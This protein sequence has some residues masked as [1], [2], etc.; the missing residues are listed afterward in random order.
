MCADLWFWEICAIIIGFLGKTELAAHVT[1]I[2]FVNVSF[3][4][5]IGLSGAGATLVGEAIGAQNLLRAKRIC[6]DIVLINV[7]GWSLIAVGIVV[8][9][10]KLATS[11]SDRNDVQVIMK[12]LLVIY[13]F[14]GFF[15]S[16]QN[17]MNGVLRGLG[18]QKVTTVVFILTFYVVMLPLGSLLSF[19]A[20][21]GCGVYGMW[22]SF[23]VGTGLAALVF[24][25]YLFR[26][27]DNNPFLQAAEH[28]H[29]PE[30][31]SSL[32]LLME[33]PLNSCPV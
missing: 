32:A 26:Q 23:G 5:V 13:A 14:A 1:A 3:M 11:Y 7:I 27:G 4:P 18:M 33:S 31:D 8:G 24:A 17:V 25:V 22:Y 2:N 30:L 9:R 15:D 10:E 6:R 19:S 21:F 28:M 16:T 20:V 12:R 29:R